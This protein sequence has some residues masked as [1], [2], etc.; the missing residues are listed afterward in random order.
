MVGARQRRCEELKYTTYMLESFVLAL[1]FQ[2]RL[3]IL[4][5][6]MHVKVNSIQM[7]MNRDERGRDKVKGCRD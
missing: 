6:A 4:E 1:R 2:H 5:A 7:S 3:I